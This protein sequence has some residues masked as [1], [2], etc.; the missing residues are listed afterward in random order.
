M[1]FD[2]AQGSRAAETHVMIGFQNTLDC[3]TVVT[4]FSTTPYR[5][6]PQSCRELNHH[7][8]TGSDFKS[9]L[10]FFSGRMTN[11]F[12]LTYAMSKLLTSSIICE[13]FFRMV[14]NRS[15]VDGPLVD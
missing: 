9:L 12:T 3:K 1:F 15:I 13:T 11:V 8:R 7:V 5:K 10:H 6:L 4:H 2:A 14:I